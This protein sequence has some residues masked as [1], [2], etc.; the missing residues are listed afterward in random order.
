[1]KDQG[2]LAEVEAV[3]EA[4]VVVAAEEATV[5]AKEEAVVEE[6]EV[7]EKKEDLRLATGEMVGEQTLH[8]L[9]VPGVIQVFM[10]KD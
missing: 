1:M 3:V 7:D 6:E 8:S 2:Y 4:A 10:E 5:E 9:Q